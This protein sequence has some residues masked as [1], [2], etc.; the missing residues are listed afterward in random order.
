LAAKDLNNLKLKAEEE[1]KEKFKL[2]EPIMEGAKASR[3]QLKSIYSVTL[4][5]EEFRRSLQSFDMD[6][7]FIIP[8]K[9][10][11]QEEEDWPATDATT[12]N[13]F[14]AG[15]N[16][17]DLVVKTASTFMMKRG[18]EF[19]VENL[20]WSGEK[21]LNSC[22]DKLRQ[23]IE[24]QTIGWLVEHATGPVYFKVMIHLILA[25]SAQSLRG[26]TATVGKIDD[27]GY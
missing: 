26:L 8:S 15:K 23:K 27:Q 9:F 25:S 2:M 19:H 20:L 18:Q 13:L 1:M 4:R 5:V 6:D 21:L 17:S 10:E 7:V 12:I 3:D 16:V 14:T 22:D 11:R 24:E